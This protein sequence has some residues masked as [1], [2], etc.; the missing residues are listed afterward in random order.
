MNT[1]QQSDFQP[2]LVDHSIHL[3]PRELEVLQLLVEGQSNVEIAASVHLSLGTV[4]TY[5]SSIFHKFGVEHRVQA[6][7][8]ALRNQLI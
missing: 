3:A 6:A 8:F 7:V 5:V 2:Y 1:V 4:K